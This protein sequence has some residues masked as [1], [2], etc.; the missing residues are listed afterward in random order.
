MQPYFLLKKEDGTVTFV[1]LYV[2]LCLPA[3]VIAYACVGLQKTTTM[4]TAGRCAGV[5][6]G[7]QRFHALLELAPSFSCVI[8]T[9]DDDVVP[10]GSISTYGQTRGR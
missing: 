5:G 9:V 2:A 7:C 1:I 8:Q 10:P 6:L 4:L 3:W